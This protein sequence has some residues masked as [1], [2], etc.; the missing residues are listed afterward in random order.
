MVVEDNEFNMNAVTNMIFRIC[1]I[2]P[3]EAQNGLIAVDKFKESLDLP[4]KCFNRAYRLIVMDIQMPE[5]DG[6]EATD[7]INKMVEEEIKDRIPARDDRGNIIKFCTIIALTSY[8]TE[9]VKTKCLEQ[10]MKKVLHK[11]VQ[12]SDIKIELDELFPLMQNQFVNQ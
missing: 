8:T 11:P 3:E 2:K 4:C 9:K 7:A 1:G 6:H 12:Y 10:G 5:M